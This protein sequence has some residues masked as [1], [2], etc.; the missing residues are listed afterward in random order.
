MLS[1]SGSGLLFFGIGGLSLVFG[2][3]GVTNVKTKKINPIT[4]LIGVYSLLSLILVTGLVTLPFTETSPG[5]I[6]FFSLIL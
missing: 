4:I 2:I 1:G 5:V 6:T 3:L